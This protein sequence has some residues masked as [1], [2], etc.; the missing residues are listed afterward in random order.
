MTKTIFTC[1]LISISLLSS[2]NEPTEES[3]S[4]GYRVL[5]D[6]NQAGPTAGRWS[7]AAEQVDWTRQTIERG[8][9]RK[10]NGLIA[11]CIDNRKFVFQKRWRNPNF[12]TMKP[13][14]K[15][16]IL[17]QVYLSKIATNLIGVI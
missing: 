8:F 2:G 9:K 14:L 5:K 11:V 7:T 12:S 1:L 17:T 10:T 15:K 6:L 3:E 4:D 16:K 13:I